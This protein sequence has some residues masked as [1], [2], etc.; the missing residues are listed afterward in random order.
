MISNIFMT[1]A[2]TNSEKEFSDYKKHYNIPMY[3]QACWQERFS[4]FKKSFAL[5]QEINSI[6]S[7]SEAEEESSV[8]Y[9]FDITH[10]ESISNCDLKEHIDT[11]ARAI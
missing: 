10:Y 4:N 11:W 7:P 3:P 5:L 2:Y 6:D 8:P 1:Y 9:F